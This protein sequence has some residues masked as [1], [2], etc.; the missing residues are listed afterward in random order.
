MKQ[1]K[2]QLLEGNYGAYYP[3]IILAPSGGNTKNQIAESRPG[4]N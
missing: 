3:E 4:E 2:L 1:G